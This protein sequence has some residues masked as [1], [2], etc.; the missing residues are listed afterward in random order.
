[1]ASPPRIHV[2]SKGLIAVKSAAAHGLS[3]AA[4]LVRG[5]TAEG[6]RDGDAQVTQAS[7]DAVDGVA[8]PWNTFAPGGLG[9]WQ[10]PGGSR[11]DAAASPTFDDPLSH[12]RHLMRVAADRNYDGSADVPHLDR[13]QAPGFVHAMERDAVYHRLPASAS[14]S[15]SMRW[16][17]PP[18][19]ASPPPDL[20]V[21]VQRLGSA[22]PAAGPGGSAPVAPQA[23]A[24]L[25]GEA[26]RRMQALLAAPGL[27]GPTSPTAA[28]A[29][30]QQQQQSRQGESR[31]A[32]SAPGGASPVVAA[33]VPQSAV[34]KA[35]KGPPASAGSSG[36]SGPEQGGAGGG[37]QHLTPGVHSATHVRR[38]RRRPP[39]D[40]AGPGADGSGPVPV[41]S[42]PADIFAESESVA[43]RRANRAA[44]DALITERLRVELRRAGGGGA[45]DD[46]GAKEGD[47]GASPPTSPGTAQYS[48]ANAFAPGPLSAGGTY[49]K[50][51]PRAVPVAKLPALARLALTAGSGGSETLSGS[52]ARSVALGAVG[53]GA[54]RLAKPGVYP[55]VLGIDPPLSLPASLQRPLQQP[56]QPD[57][58]APG[59]KQPGSA[60]GPGAPPQQQQRRRSVTAPMVH[61]VQSSAQITAARAGDPVAKQTVWQE[62]LEA[63]EATP[64]ALGPLQTAMPGG[65]AGPGGRQLEGMRRASVTLTGADADAAGGAAGGGFRSAVVAAEMRLHSARVFC[66]AL[67][68][69][70]DLATAVALDA[71][72]TV[73]A[74][75]QGPGGTSVTAWYASIIRECQAVL[76]QARGGSGMGGRCVVGAISPPS[77]P[78][79]PSTRSWRSPAPST[80]PRC[81][82]APCTPPPA[83]T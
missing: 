66:A 78:C 51:A 17:P 67:G 6:G 1:M 12:H 9:E 28:V 57:A 4:D 15:S 58:A 71:L 69:P 38:G 25:L 63:Y 7:P 21:T 32:A 27:Q 81:C 62:W 13:R 53:G 68:R 76:A 82:P 19:S 52:D 36:S 40:S 8:G 2:S 44:L 72:D 50:R 46:E 23:S 56:Q 14:Q 77:R 10:A 54:A 41:E 64:L 43:E 24:S 61:L 60:W 79:R 49:T 22:N 5:W 20:A 83:S 35:H 48:A 29:Q 74:S 33:L 31:G 75:L 42:G 34:W 3:S 37:Q 45:S 39:T 47:R 80:R 70:A 73:I 16:A 11:A 30:Q 59:H 65:A 18:G 55:L 26:G